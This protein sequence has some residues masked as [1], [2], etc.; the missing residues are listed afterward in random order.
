M[1]QAI[2]INFAP[3]LFV[4]F[5]KS[6]NLNYALIGTLIFLHFI[7]QLFTDIFSVF[8]IDRL[9]YRVSAFSSQMCCAAG[10][11]LLPVLPNIMPSPFLGICIALIFY[12]VGAGLIEV[13]INPVMASVPDGRGEI[14]FLHS[15]YS[16]GQLL[17]V[18]LTTFAIKIFGSNSWGYI[19]LLWGTV[20]FCNALAFLKAPI[21]DT[22]ES[23]K[24][25]KIG[26]L[27]KNKVFI[28]IIILMICA[29]GSELAMSQWASTFAQ[30]ALGV[31]KL[32]GDLLGPCLFAVFMGIGR[33]IYGIK[34]DKLNYKL[35]MSVSAVLCIVCYVV[36]AFA[37]NPYAALLGCAVCGYAISI[38][39]PGVVQIA[40]KLF[41]NGSGA[42]YGFIAIFG[43]VGCSIAPFITGI[44]ASISAFGESSL[45][46]GLISNVVYPL[47]FLLIITK[48]LKKSS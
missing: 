1:T 14:I 28:C 39:W 33:T 34:A 20:P 17:T 9:G 5:Q 4:I 47:G 41:P 46:V 6:Y 37:K 12:S 29:G 27:L 38:M 26:G 19:S 24:R 43:D 2:I 25:E 21:V 22:I 48:L 15:F 45:K 7:V 3:L 31:D 23:E 30:N 42:M 10:L 32:T 35:H 16:W 11:F 40:A 8:F 44:I 36:A 18:L 13:V